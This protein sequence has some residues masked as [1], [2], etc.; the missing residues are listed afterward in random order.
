MKAIR[1]TID[2]NLFDFLN[3]DGEVA[4][5]GKSEFFRRAVSYY[6]HQREKKNIAKSYERGYGNNDSKEEFANKV[7]E[8]ENEQVWPEQ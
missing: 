4:S 1:I 3:S 5:I 6:L 7:Q 2:E 8:W